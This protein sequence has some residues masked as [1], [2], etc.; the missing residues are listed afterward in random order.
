MSPDSRFVITAAVLAAAAV[1]QVPTV[2][3]V[4]DFVVRAFVTGAPA[5]EDRVLLGTVLQPG[6]AVARTALAQA[7]GLTSDVD[8]SVALATAGAATTLTLRGVGWN[9]F[10]APPFPVVPRQCSLDY[11][12]RLRLPA[13]QR[14]R[15]DLDIWFT[16]EPSQGMGYAWYSGEVDI[17]DDGTPEM[18][19]GYPGG[20]LLLSVEH[21]AG[22]LHIRIRGHARVESTNTSTADH[23]R[24]WFDLFATSVPLADFV[25]FGVG[26]AGSVGVPELRAAPGSWPVPGNPFRM[27]FDNLPLNPGVAFGFAGTGPVPGGFPL[28]L[29]AIGMPGCLQYLQ[30]P[31]FVCWMVGHQ[32]GSAEW[33][34]PIP[35]QPAVMGIPFLAQGW[36]LDAVANPLGAIVTNAGAGIVG[37]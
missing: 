29:G 32:G 35:N 27:V 21:P 26:C 11:D 13:S 4:D 2:E 5:V 33:L 28:D 24:I 1:A 25:P 34:L 20:R 17:G 14:T 10:L 18:S 15:H 36:V 37:A 7:Q 22:E 8:A 16:P 23:F 12:L 30:P 3:F 6:Q 31:P 19:L 9:D